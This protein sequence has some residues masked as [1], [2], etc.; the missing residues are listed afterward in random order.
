MIANLMMY[1][2]PELAGAHDRYWQLIRTA[3]RDAGIDSP[4]TLSQDSEEFFVWN[5]PELVLSQTCGMP[6]RTWLHDKVELVGTPDFGIAGCPPGYYRSALVVRANAPQT[7]M[8]AF[9]G[10]RFAY[11]Q[12]FSQ[13][14]YA[15][16]YWHVTPRGF[17]FEDRLQ[18]EAHLESAKAVADGRADIASLD[19]VTWRNI[20]RYEPFTKELRVLEWTKPTPGLPLITAPGNDADAIFEAVTKA[21]A[22]LQ[23]DDRL[24]LGIRGIVKIPKEDYLKVPNPD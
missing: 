2:R 1:R 24:L 20:E 17:W 15:A 9:M 19:A 7:D 22:D 6:Y 16:P 8:D 14:G 4:E 3:L 23:D 18:T 5:H 10:A 11:N 21:I 13:S 12:T